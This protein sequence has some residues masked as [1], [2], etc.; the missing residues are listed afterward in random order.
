MARSRR[1]KLPAG[2]VRAAIDNLS[3]EGRGV[4]RV[5]GKTVFVENALPGETVSFNYS[6]VHRNHDE[7]VAEAVL[8][9]SPERA[10]PRCPHY[11]VC[12]GCA[13]QHLEHLAQVRF[14]QRLM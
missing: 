1:R 10:E 5:E 8:E 3:H 14:K 9:P 7:G 11:A 12:G 6:A 13:L 4:A 2:P